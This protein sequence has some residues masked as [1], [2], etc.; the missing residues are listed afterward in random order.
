MSGTW[1]T[2]ESFGDGSPSWT[3]YGTNPAITGRADSA[4][5]WRF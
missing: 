3:I 1:L 4:C 5:E 2:D